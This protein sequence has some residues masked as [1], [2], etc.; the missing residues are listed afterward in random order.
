MVKLSVHVIG[1]KGV[2]GSAT[3]KTLESNDRIKVT[4]SDVGEQILEADII[5]IC[6]PEVIV[7]ELLDVI[8]DFKGLK[9]IRSTVRPDIISQ[10]SIKYPHFC[11]N[12]EFLKAHT[13]FWDCYYPKGVL[14]GECCIQHGDRLAQ[15]WSFLNVP[16]Y[17]MSRAEASMLKLASNVHAASVITF[18]NMMKMLCDSLNLNSFKI[19]RTLPLLDERVT[20]YGTIPGAA[21]GGACLPKDVRQMTILCRQVGAPSVLLR[22]LEEVNSLFPE[23]TV[24]RGGI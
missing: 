1:N 24:A 15:V 12:P 16:I 3:Q 10:L 9:V 20:R 19:A 8:A 23:S 11:T 14:I 18:W 21:Y 4:G 6:V 7:P 13:S 22:A 17:R 5:F 2:V